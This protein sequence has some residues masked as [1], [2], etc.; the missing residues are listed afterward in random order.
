MSTIKITPF[1][2]TGF[3]DCTAIRMEFIGGDYTDDYISDVFRKG[4]VSEIRRGRDDVDV[5]IYFSSSLEREI[6]FDATNEIDGV[7]Y[8]TNE[9]FY[10]ALCLAIYG[11]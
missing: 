11:A 3:A 10:E 7:T 8:A 4:D 6:A 5:D 9:L 2:G 1:N